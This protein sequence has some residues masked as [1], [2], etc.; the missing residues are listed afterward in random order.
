M[1]TLGPD[2]G[3]LRD[4]LPQGVE[5]NFHRVEHARSDGATVTRV[6]IIKY[7]YRYGLDTTASSG[8]IGINGYTSKFYHLTNSQIMKARANRILSANSGA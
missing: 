8:H 4:N 1:H 3:H 2:W 5:Q 6:K 7:R